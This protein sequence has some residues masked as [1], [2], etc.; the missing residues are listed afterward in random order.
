MTNYD[1]MAVELRHQMTNEG[2]PCPQNVMLLHTKHILDY[3]VLSDLWQ[4]FEE[5]PFL[6]QHH[7][8]PV[9]KARFIK[10]LVV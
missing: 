5:D 10:K 8:G 3:S 4:Q 6:F 2:Y 7:S 1:Q 9:H